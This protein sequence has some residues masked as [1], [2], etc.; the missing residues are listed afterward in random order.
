MFLILT[1]HMYSFSNVYFSYKLFIQQNYLVSECN[2][3][4]SLEVAESS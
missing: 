1:I 4:S 3:C 2:D